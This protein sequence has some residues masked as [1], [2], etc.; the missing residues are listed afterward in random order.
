MSFIRFSFLLFYF[1]STLSTRPSFEILSS[2]TYLPNPS[3]KP[4]FL[5]YP[6]PSCPVNL[7][8]WLAAA[9]VYDTYYLPS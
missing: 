8:L 2:S 5:S 6:I 3:K 9:L 4:P 7:F 1:P